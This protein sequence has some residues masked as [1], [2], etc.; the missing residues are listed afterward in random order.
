[1]VFEEPRDNATSR[2]TILHHGYPCSSVFE[3]SRRSRSPEARL[4]FVECTDKHVYMV[5]AMPDGSTDVRDYSF[6]RK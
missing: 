6:V 4:H 2:D 5:A 3:V 1:V